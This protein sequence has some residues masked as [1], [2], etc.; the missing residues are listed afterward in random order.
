MN[1]TRAGVVI[2]EGEV[3]KKKTRRFRNLNYHAF[4]NDQISEPMGFEYWSE[5][6]RA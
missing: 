2:F 4:D 5:A 3:L 1:S 6:W